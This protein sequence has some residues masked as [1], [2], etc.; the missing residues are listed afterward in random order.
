MTSS[1][2]QLLSCQ[3]ALRA[4]GCSAAAQQT[5]WPCLALL[6]QL[7]QQAARGLVTTGH[8]HIPKAKHDRYRTPPK[9]YVQLLQHITRARELGRLEQLVKQYGPKFD[10]VHVA[11]AMSMLPK[12]HQP[13]KPGSRLSP[14]KVK[15]R[16]VMPAKLLLQL[17]DM[18]AAQVPR[19]FAREVAS[20][21]W[22]LGRC[23]N[24]LP[25]G[26][27][28]PSSS[29]SSSSSNGTCLNSTT[30]QLVRQLML[31]LHQGGSRLL[32]QGAS[33]AE[34][35]KLLHGMA[36]LRLTWPVRRSVR[37]LCVFVQRHPERMHAKELAAAAWALSKLPVEGEAVSG[38]LAVISEQAV[39]RKLWLRPVSICSLATAWARLG[40]SDD[41]QLLDALAEEAVAQIKDFRPPQLAV[42]AWAFGRLR[43]NPGQETLAALST[44]AVRQL[45]HFDALHLGLLLRG[46]TR[47]QGREMDKQLLS[48]VAAGIAKEQAVA[49]NARDA[50]RILAAFVAAP[51]A[52]H[53][54][55][56][57]G[58]AERIGD[59]LKQRISSIKPEAAT[60][61]LVCYSKLPVQHELLL[62]LADSAAE[63]ASDFSMRQWVRMVKACKRLGYSRLQDARLVALYAAADQRLQQHLLGQ[64]RRQ[65]QRAAAH[66]SCC[67]KLSSRASMR[68]SSM[69]QW[70]W[71]SC[72]AS[73]GR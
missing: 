16:L 10:G 24:L 67:R 41:M 30:L 44:S 29:S 55:D 32:Y 39:Q 38:A 6:S 25:Q 57:T 12:L 73:A 15:E 33:G 46:L 43:Y 13:A 36:R 42:L 59:A 54:R 47:L 31:R 50:V 66:S 51:D 63:R 53:V 26:S 52:G 72:W 48:E 2:L 22:A 1:T 14:Q 17:Q 49:L 4:L 69:Q 35:A 68:C 56:V 20:V 71:Q 19:M 11:A 58:M 9:N 37:E 62:R 64:P 28:R 3:G 40:R 45:E 8:T 60:N 65:Q 5:Q 27:S 7:G 34:V 70:T 21:T 23:R 18:A 61:L